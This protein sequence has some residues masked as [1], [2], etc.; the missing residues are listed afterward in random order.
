MRCAL[1][2]RASHPERNPI[3]QANEIK[4]SLDSI[5]ECADEAKRAATSASSDLKQSVEQLHQQARQAQQACSTAG[6]AQQQGD[7]SQLR[8]PVMQLEQAADRA[9]QA[10]RKAGSVDPQLKDAVQ[11]AHQQASQ[12]KKQVQMG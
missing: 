3:M 9:M 1:T 12:L 8:E 2:L 11:R 4:Q 6:G 7:Q 10:V 5:E